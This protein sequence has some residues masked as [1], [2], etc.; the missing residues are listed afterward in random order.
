MNPFSKA[1]LSI[2]CFLVEIIRVERQTSKDYKPLK[3]L[4]ITDARALWRA[5]SGVGFPE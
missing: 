4:L 2:R 1:D 5:V 3:P